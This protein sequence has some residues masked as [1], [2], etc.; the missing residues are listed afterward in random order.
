[1]AEEESAFKEF[2]RKAVERNLPRMEQS[3]V[4]L[5]IFDGHYAEN[6]I[7]ILQLGLAILLDKPIYMLVPKG[8]KVPEKLRRA[9]DGIEEYHPD[10]LGIATRRLMERA[11][12][13]QQR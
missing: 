7:C 9:A 10:D 1:M 8:T 4:F 3:A 11:T 13:E 6:A 12:K 2:A 5:A